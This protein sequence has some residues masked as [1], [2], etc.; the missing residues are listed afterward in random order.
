MKKINSYIL[1]SI[2]LPFFFFL[3]ALSLLVWLSQSL[4]FVDLI[5]N[6]NLQVSTF[7][8]LSTL[9]LPG[10]LVTVIP[11]ALFA[12][13]VFAYQRLVA[14]SE[15]V[16]FWA[17]GVGNRQL[18][19]PVLVVALIS[20]I[21]SYSF[22]LYLAPLGARALRDLRNNINTDLSAILL[23][24]GTFN[25]VGKDLTVY[26]RARQRNGEML[27]ILVHDNRDPRRPG[28]NDGGTGRPGLCCR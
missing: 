20:V 19:F 16:V 25:T 11:I 3:G 28:D 23:R 10:I 8:Y 1:R 26:I 18:A 5:I 24:E 22:S 7:L 13:V 12:A 2:L 27:G 9:V 4:R 14:D 15:V 17:T 21:L 6:Q